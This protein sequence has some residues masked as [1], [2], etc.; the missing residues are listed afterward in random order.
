MSDMDSEVKKL[1]QVISAVFEGK[2]AVLC[3]ST[4]MIL[5]SDMISQVYEEDPETAEIYYE[6][7]APFFSQSWA[8][9]EKDDDDV[10]V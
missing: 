3:L 7:L 9:I 8:K 4:S 1:C 2:N 5:I 6:N 10:L